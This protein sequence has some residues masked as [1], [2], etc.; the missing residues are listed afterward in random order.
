VLLTEGKSLE[1]F[2]II[3]DGEVEV[4]RDG[5]PAATL[6]RGDCLGAMHRIHGDELSEFTASYKKDVKLFTVDRQDVLDFVEG[7]PG[8]G[9]KLS[10][11]YTLRD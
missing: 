4:S 2:F 8:V 9:M 11:Q 1:Q 5:H 7:N 6:G 3:R 10:Y